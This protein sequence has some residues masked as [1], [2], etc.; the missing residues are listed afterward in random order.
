MKRDYNKQ[1]RNILK[2]LRDFGK[3]P[4]ARI[5]A[6]VGINYNYLKALLDDLEKDGKIVSEKVG[7]LATYWK[8]KNNDS[9]T[10]YKDVAMNKVADFESRFKKGF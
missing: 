2:V 10:N 3:L 9:T 5:S 6:I 4:S 8:L 7:D 1:K